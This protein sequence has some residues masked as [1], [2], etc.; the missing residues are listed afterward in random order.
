MDDSL[1]HDMGISRSEVRGALRE[2]S[3]LSPR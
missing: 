2:R 1:L 3:D